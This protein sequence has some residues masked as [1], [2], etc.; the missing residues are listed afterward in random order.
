MERYQIPGY[1]KWEKLGELCKTTSGGTP[2]RRNTH[3]FQGDIPWVKS[4]ELT[5][6]VVT[7]VEEYITQEAEQNSSAK[8]FPKGTLLLAMYGATVGKLGIL[9]RDA[10]TNQA[11]CAIFPPSE[12]ESSFLFWFLRRCRPELLALSAGGAQPNISQKI[13]RE[14]DIPIP[15]PDDP[16]RS[17]AEQR[18]IV[19][20]IEALF[21]ELRGCRALNEKIQKDR[22]NLLS[23]AIGHVMDNIDVDVPVVELSKIGTAF[24]G[25]ASGQGDSSVRVFKTR[26]VYPF[27]LRFDEPSFM[28][29]EQV[30]K[31]P[32]DRYL[33]DDDVLLCNIARG[34]LGRPSHV[35]HVDGK[36][37]T[38]TSVMILRTD[39]SCLGK[40][41]FYCLYSH[42]GQ[43]EI[44]AREKGIAFADKRGQTHLYPRDMQTFPIML[45]SITEQSQL[46]DYLDA[47]QS[48]QTDVVDIQRTMDIQTQ[49]LEQSVLAK[50]FRGEL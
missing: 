7:E 2:S 10:A 11:V 50:A 34:T 17:L 5:D 23:S 29:E 41:L 20:R 43:E 26:H 30:A 13:I 14:L 6:G 8:V 3:Y 49:A 24:N 25:R 36:W 15:Y 16:T 18:R 42:R 46:V 22:D 4:G 33:Q 45:P 37:T 27:D 9:G 39:E 48:V 32:E 31:C 35:E 28:K 19:A 38:D 12:I 21:A 1:W 40:W 44:F 47:I